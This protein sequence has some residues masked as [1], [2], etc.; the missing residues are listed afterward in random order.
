LRDSGF[1]GVT[2]SHLVG[3]TSMVFGYKPGRLTKAH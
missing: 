2:T 3:P 1:N